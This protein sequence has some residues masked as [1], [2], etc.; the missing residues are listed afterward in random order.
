MLKLDNETLLLDFVAATGLA[1]L[2]Q[3]VIL[4]AIYISVRHAV[5]RVRDEAEELRSAILPVISSARDMF[6]RIAPQI[7]SAAVDLAAITSELRVQ[8][9]EMQRSAMEILD[10]VHRQSS[11]LD[12]MFSDA[13]DVVDRAGTFIADVVNR[14]LRQI[15]GIMATVKAVVDTL[16]P[17]QAPQRPAAA[18]RGREDRF[19]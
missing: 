6:T 5:R 15:S 3:A 18:P 11:R 19:V 10:R 2:L 17:H 9:V 1:V 8:S 7:E 13:L 16:R 14:P 12:T 4:L